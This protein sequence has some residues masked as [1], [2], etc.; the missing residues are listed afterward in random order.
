MRTL[1]T[2]IV[3]QMALISASGTVAAQG[4]SEPQADQRA[5]NERVKAESLPISLDRIRKELAQTP[6]TTETLTDLRLEYYIQVY[7]TAPK[8]DLIGDFN[9]KTGPVPYG[10]PTHREFVD[11]VTPEEFRTRPADL[12]AFVTW[13]A[14]RLRS[15]TSR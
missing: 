8:I 10:G 5:A 2:L 3:A 14:D 6:R 1:I 13:L 15:K 4:V 9:V 7:G 12:T 11:F